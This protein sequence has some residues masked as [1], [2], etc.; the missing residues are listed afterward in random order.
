M[1]S[2]PTFG[3]NPASRSS[4]NLCLRNPP[5]HVDV[6][7][8]KTAIILGTRPE[9]IKL[10]PLIRKMRVTPGFEPHV[11]A[12]G[13]HHELLDRALATFGVVP[14]VNMRLMRVGQSLG[15][16]TAK[17]M[18]GLDAYLANLRPDLVIVQGDTT[19]TFCGGLAA[20]YRRIPVAHV[21]AGLRTHDPQSPFPEEFNR[22]SISHIAQ[23]HFAPTE[24]AV[25]NLVAEGI[26]RERIHLTGNTGIDALRFAVDRNLREAPTIPNLPPHILGGSAP[27]VLITAHRRENL[28]GAIEA[29]CQAISILSHRFP[30]THFVLPVHPNPSVEN[31]IRRRLRG[32]T[33]VYLIPPLDYLPFVALLSNSSLIITDSGGL[34]EEAA[35]LGIPLIVTRSIQD[36]PT[37][38]SLRNQPALSATKIAAHAE[39]LLRE[40]SSSGHTVPADSG[41]PSPLPYGDGRAS[42]RILSILSS[43]GSTGV[44]AA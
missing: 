38:E 3:H 19:T 30:E 6:K 12:T 41:R 43:G 20:F 13:Q 18:A 10:C 34:Q 44:K 16:L 37:A 4:H 23:Y 35:T 15:S 22:T 5:S 14:D 9:A 24:T 42:G 11:C 33:N 28:D 17:L 32:R 7:R 29:V 2:I 25:E 1:I 26:S 27:L 31:T 36:R 21:E 8:K 39:L 40:E